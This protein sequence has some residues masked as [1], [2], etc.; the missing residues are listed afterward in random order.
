M[1]RLIDAGFTV[2]DN[3]YERRLTE[4][5]LTE[6]LDDG[7]TGIIAG[8]EPLGRNVLET[9]ELKV[10]SRCG[11]GISNVDRKAAD[12]LGIRVFST[13]DGPTTAVAELTLGALLGLLR[14]I[15]QADRHLHERDWLKIMGR[16]LSGATAVVV[17]YGRI[18]REVG[19]LLA[20]FGAE[21]VAVDPLLSESVDDARVLDLEEALPIADIVTLHASGADCILGS[22]EL[23]QL[24]PGAYLLNAGRGELIDETALLHALSSGVVEGAWLD[25]FS[26]EPYDGPLC[27]LNQVLLTPHLG[28]YTG[29]CRSAME[30]EAVEN[31]VAGFEALER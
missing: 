11:S 13:P 27:D 18:G 1:E 16:Q 15:P 26:Q 22:T 29:E 5:E 8:L 10:I 9:S 4:Q 24:K 6:L 21:V 17:G 28:S 23:R 25:T 12:E 2:T 19:R 7:Y 20:A 31:L 14:S 30:S 3:P